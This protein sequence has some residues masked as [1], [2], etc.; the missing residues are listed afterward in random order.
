MINNRV[1]TKDMSKLTQIPVEA[2]RAY[3][4]EEYEITDFKW[5]ILEA[6]MKK[7]IKKVPVV[8]KVPKYIIDALNQFD[9]SIIMK[10]KIKNK[11]QEFID[12]LR[13]LGF[14]CRMYD[15]GD[16]HYVIENKKR[17]T[18]KPNVKVIFD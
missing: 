6:G 1:S 13:K 3:L 9:N 15:T 16:D 2:I 5:R 11:E 4:R 12:D 17:F 14:K 10:K 8:S 18:R 7:H